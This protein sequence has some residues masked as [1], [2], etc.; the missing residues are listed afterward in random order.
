M[1]DMDED[2]EQPWDDFTRVSQLVCF[3]T[4]KTIKVLMFSRHKDCDVTWLYGPLQLGVKI[5]HSTQIEPSS[6]SL[7]KNDSLVN[8]DK[9]PILKK[10][11]MS[12]VMLQR[13]LSNV[14]LLKQAIAAIQTEGTSGILRLHP[15]PA[16]MN[17]FVPPFLMGMGGR[18]TSLTPSTGSTAIT[19]PSVER[20][21]I[22]FNEHVEQCI[23]VDVN[24]GNDEEKD[25]DSDRYDR[26]SDPDIGFMMKRIKI[27][28]RAPLASKRTIAKTMSDD[29][30]TIA[31]LPST[32]LKYGE[33]TPEPRETAMKHSRSRLMSLASSQEALRPTTQPVKF[34]LGEEDIL[35]DAI[36]SPHSGC[37]SPPAEGA[38]I[39]LHR[40][41]SSSG[42]CDEPAGMRRTPSGMFMPYDEN[43]LT[44]GDGIFAQLIDTINTARDIAHVIWNAGRRE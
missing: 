40:S 20:K 38:G 22:H 36:L 27:K 12:E 16:T 33:D 25:V 10:R 6:V 11:S 9:K 32:T 31:M 39:G 8:L 30:K 23:A 18:S 3:S 19:S 44:P 43:D 13:S 2:Q 42:V 34:F 29:A 24:G 26:N 37:A 15:E 14:S 17:N 35:D 4:L 21:H 41:A 28:K 5:L 7:S 1:E